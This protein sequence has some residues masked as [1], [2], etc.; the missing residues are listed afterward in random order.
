MKEDAK[1]VAGAHRR[2]VRCAVKE[3]LYSWSNIAHLTIINYAIVVA[4]WHLAYPKT[5]CR[6]G[7]RHCKRSY[8]SAVAA[9]REQL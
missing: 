6:V 9:A 5:S 7:T 2:L 3:Y 8:S 4:G 1:F